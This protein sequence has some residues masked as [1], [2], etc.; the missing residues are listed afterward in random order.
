MLVSLL[1]Q[2]AFILYIDYI[3]VSLFLIIIQ[4]IAFSIVLMLCYLAT[5]VACAL[6]AV[7]WR[8]PPEGCECIEELSVPLTATNALEAVSISL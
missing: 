7:A 5:G 4:E 8:E 1:Y 3:L 2:W 6:Y